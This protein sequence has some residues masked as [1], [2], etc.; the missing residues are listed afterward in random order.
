VFAWHERPDVVVAV[1]AFGL[2]RADAVH[3]AEGVDYD[4]GTPGQTVAGPGPHPTPRCAV[5]PPGAR[6]RQ[7][8]LK[9]SS[10]PGVQA[11][12]KLARLSDLQ[13]LQPTGWCDN[14]PCPGRA[15]RVGD[16]PD[17]AAGIVPA[18]LPPGTQPEA[19]MAPGDQPA[20]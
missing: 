19:R 17:R 12:A 9:T 1:I 10:R 13:R 15:R 7:D 6:T 5:V 8:M 2:G 18:L 14:S 16:P 20:E 3:V 11:A 4:P